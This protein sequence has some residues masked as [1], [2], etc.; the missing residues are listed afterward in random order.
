[1]LLVVAFIAMF[2]LLVL[3][4]LVNTL[5]QQ[6]VQGLITHTLG[7][8]VAFGAQLLILFYTFGSAVI[9]LQMIRDNISTPFSYWFGNEWYTDPRFLVTLYT[10]CIPGPLSY[11]KKMA[12][13]SY[14]ST[15]GVLFVIYAVVFVAAEGAVYLST[16]S[17]P[18]PVIQGFNPSIQF[19]VGLPTIVFA[20]M[21]HVGFVPIAA[22]LV[23][24][25]MLRTGLVVSTSFSLCI[26]LYFAIGVPAYLRIGQACFDN[27]TSIECISKFPQFN[28]SA[29]AAPDL[30]NILNFYPANFIPAIV[31]RFGM[32]LTLGMGYPLSTFVG[33]LTLR[34]LFNRN[35]EF[36]SFMY[37][38]ITTLWVVTTLALAIGIKSIGVV[39]TFVGATAGSWFMMVFPALMLA[40]TIKG[41]IPAVVG[42]II[43]A[44]FGASTGIIAIVAHFL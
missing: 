36:S 30:S 40:V 34:T 20:F 39:F 31:G 32:C 8:R 16:E 26:V 11:L 6:T 27:V 10:V 17:N 35:R 28:V 41:N 15:A 7:K 33:R 18:P 4:Y 5:N 42:C 24:P 21:T 2:T 14:G 44:V 22:E 37:V 23:N 12:Y 38:L 43:L 3:T 25:T 29:S 19:V 1:M 13:L 9:Y